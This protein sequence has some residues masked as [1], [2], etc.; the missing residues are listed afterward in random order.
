VARVGRSFNDIALA[1]KEIES[2]NAIV[3]ARKDCALTS[4]PVEDVVRPRTMEIAQWKPLQ[5]A[6]DRIRA[7]LDEQPGVA[8]LESP[9]PDL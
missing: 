1:V 7:A 9:G 6:F 4:Y 8:S 2:G 3:F 5:V